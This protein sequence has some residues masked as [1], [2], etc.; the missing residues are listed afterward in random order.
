MA[1]SFAAV[2]M[3][4]DTCRF[5]TS[6]ETAPEDEEVADVLRTALDAMKAQGAEVVDAVV[7][8]LDDLLRDSSV[9]SDEFKFDLANYLAKHPG[10]SV[11]S[12]GEILDRGLHHEALDQTL[13]QRNAPQQRNSEHY[14][15]ALIKRRALK[16]AVQSALEL[17]RLDALVYPTLRRKPAPIGEEQRPSTITSTSLI[18]GTCRLSA[19][20]GLPA[21]SVP[22][23]F[24]G[25]GLPIGLEMLG[26]AF[27][28]PTLLRFA[29][30][31]EQAARPRRAPF[32][33][34][35][36]VNGGAPTPRRAAMTTGVGADGAVA[37]LIFDSTTGL[38]DYH[39]TV[40]G[41]ARV[42]AVA[43]HRTDGDRPGPIV[44]HLLRRGQRTGRGSIALRFRDREDLRNG[45][46]LVRLYTERLPLG[47]TATRVSFP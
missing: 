35:P 13:R 46:M 12:L 5:D 19:T 18:A 27:A 17:Q 10:A 40:G 25:D 16:D 11:R 30:A 39:V 1:A 43:L 42:L 37:T 33:T 15:L 6:A 7:P 9:I 41:D 23:G 31:W 34:P 2:G 36:L 21:L 29:Y 20:T 47:T 44:A 3:G 22:A 8:G 24:S 32:S 38:L 28:E 14:R 26:R 45:R 4:T